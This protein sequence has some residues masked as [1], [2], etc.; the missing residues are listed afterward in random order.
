[1]S[2][3]KTFYIRLPDKPPA[4]APYWKF[5]FKHLVGKAIVVDTD[6]CDLGDLTRNVSMKYRRDFEFADK[7]FKIE[8]TFA[9]QLVISS[10]WLEDKRSYM[11]D[12]I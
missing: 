11:L 2:G 7:T 1:M 9:K 5:W 3:I 10:L 4:T 8:H 6:Y 12:I